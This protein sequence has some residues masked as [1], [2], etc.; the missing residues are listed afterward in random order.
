MY[1]EGQ[2]IPAAAAAAHLKGDIASSQDSA[3]VI[4]TEGV[5][6][7]GGGGVPMQHQIVGD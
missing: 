1:A 2:E 5:L 6:A 3:G 4:G 7:F